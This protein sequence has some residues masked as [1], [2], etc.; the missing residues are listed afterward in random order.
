[1]KGTEWKR[2]VRQAARPQERAGWK[3]AVRNERA[4][5]SLGFAR[6]KAAPLQEKGTIY[7]ASPQGRQGRRMRWRASGA[8]AKRATFPVERHRDA[9]G[10]KVAATKEERDHCCSK[11][12]G[13]R[14]LA[15]RTRFAFSAPSPNNEADTSFREKAS[16]IFEFPVLLFPVRGFPLRFHGG[17]SEARFELRIS[18]FEFEV[19]T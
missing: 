15:A 11:G 16:S 8:Q 9:R 1:M 3:P 14:G 18:S 12:S 19:S 7:R 17:E 6:D 4:Q 10:A 13:Y 2:A 5:R